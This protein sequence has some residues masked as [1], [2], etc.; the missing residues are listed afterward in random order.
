MR[1]VA[2]MK[3]LALFSLLLRQLRA[4]DLP[5]LL[6]GSAFAIVF[7]GS[8]SMILHVITD[9]AGYALNGVG[10]L[11]AAAVILAGLFIAKM[12]SH[13]L[14]LSLIDALSVRV[15]TRLQARTIEMLQNGEIPYPTRYVRWC[16]R[17]LLLRQMNTFRLCMRSAVIMMARDVPSLL[18]LHLVMFIHDWRMA[19]LS[20]VVLPT[21]LV[22]LGILGRRARKRQRAT[23]ADWRR[24]LDSVLSLQNPG[25]VKGAVTDI[26]PLTEALAEYRKS[27]RNAQKSRFVA[28]SMVDWPVGI[29]I[30]G[31]L[32]Y[33]GLSGENPLMPANSDASDAVTFLIGAIMAY[34]PLKRIANGYMRIGRYRRAIRQMPVLGGTFDQL[35][36]TAKTTA[37]QVDESD[38]ANEML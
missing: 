21:S 12:V 6:A 15:M 17:Q 10:G 11:V 36:G 19:L 13:F 20:C 4:T 38:D 34:Q 14:H 33:L 24:A 29:L 1:H 32:L 22:T 18:G 23:E 9:P 3:I 8:T 30:C 37:E 7:A 25:D 5:L 28:V 2:D 26:A 27:F 35:H 31:S 16:L